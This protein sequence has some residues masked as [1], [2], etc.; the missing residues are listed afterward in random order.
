MALDSSFRG[1]P[2]AK[3]DRNVG[4]IAVVA[5]RRDDGAFRAEG[6]IA[7]MTRTNDDAEFGAGVPVGNSSS[8]INVVPMEL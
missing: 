8:E 2:I 4:A 3:A 5:A 6:S 7:D 1:D